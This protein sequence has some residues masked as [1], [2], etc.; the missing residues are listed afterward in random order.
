[1][2]LSRINS[3]V[4]SSRS[5]LLLGVS[6][7]LFNPFY[8]DDFLISHILWKNRHPWHM[9]TS[10]LRLCRYMNQRSMIRDENETSTPLDMNTIFIKRCCYGKELL[11]INGIFYF[12]FIQCFGIVRTRSHCAIGLLLQQD[13]ANSFVRGVRAYDKRFT[14]T[15]AWS[16]QQ[17]NGG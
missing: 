12:C 9:S 15:G 3:S 4:K 13:C 17:R 11:I 16:N 7:S 8:I 1:M 10:N 6:E 14:R 2:G 5:S